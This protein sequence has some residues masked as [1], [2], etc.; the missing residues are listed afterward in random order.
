MNKFSIIFKCAPFFSSCRIGM[1]LWMGPKEFACSIR[2]L[3]KLEEWLAVLKAFLCSLKRV[4]K[5]LPVCPTKPCTRLSSQPTHY[6]P[7]QIYSSR[8]Y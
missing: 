1:V 3:E 4:A 5:F 8:F 7:R 6:V 2:C